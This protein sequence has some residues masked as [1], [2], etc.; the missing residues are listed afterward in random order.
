MG[1]APEAGAVEPDPPDDVVLD[2]AALDGCGFAGAVPAA[3][4]LVGAV[5]DA[6]VSA[7]VSRPAAAD[8]VPG[9]A[10]VA[11]PLEL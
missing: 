1:V 7:A 10:S 3:G 9:P 6:A 5:L 11:V 2:S 4:I 8:V